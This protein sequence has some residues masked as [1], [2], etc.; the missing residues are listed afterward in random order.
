MSENQ[1]TKYLED[2]YVVPD[3]KMDEKNFLEIEKKYLTLHQE[4]KTNEIDESKLVN[5]ILKRG[6]IS[7]HDV[8]M[9]NDSKKNKSPFQRR[10]MTMRFMPLSSKFNYNFIFDSDPQFRIKKIYPVRN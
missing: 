3:F 4:L 2:G 1:I 10:A 6:Q 8:Y 7:L 9:V 5:L